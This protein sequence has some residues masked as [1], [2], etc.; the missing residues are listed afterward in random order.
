MVGRAS[1]KVECSD[2]RRQVWR[3][4]KTKRQPVCRM[5]AQLARLNRA[6]HQDAQ[7]RFVDSVDLQESAA[8][9][10]L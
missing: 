7:L 2:D 9:P 1:L 3:Q 6:H 8:V 4:E 5:E 10:L